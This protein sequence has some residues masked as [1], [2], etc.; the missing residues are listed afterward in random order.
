M[1]SNIMIA[2]LLTLAAGL[3]GLGAYAR[4]QARRQQNT[5]RR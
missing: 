2:A 3:L 1:A 4:L 5:Q